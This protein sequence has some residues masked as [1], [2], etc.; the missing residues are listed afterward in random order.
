LISMLNPVV[1]NEKIKIKI[2][3]DYNSSKMAT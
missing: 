2:N 1:E 3:S